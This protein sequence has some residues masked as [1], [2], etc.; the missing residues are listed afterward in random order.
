MNKG[1]GQK[2]SRRRLELAVADIKSGDRT[3]RRAAKFSG[4]PELL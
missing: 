1:A 4:Y 2:Y 3:R